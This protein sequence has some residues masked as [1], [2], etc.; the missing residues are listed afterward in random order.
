MAPRRAPVSR[1]ETEFLGAPALRSRMPWNPDT[2]RQFAAERAAPAQDLLGLISVR[3]RRVIDLGCG[4]GEHTAEL[5]GRFPAAEVTGLDSSAEMLGGAR[6]YTQP[7]LT[8]EQARIEDLAGAY[9]LIFSNAALQWLPKHRELLA[10]LWSHLHPG[11]QL[12]VQVPSN[13]DHPS[14]RLLAETAQEAPFRGALGDWTRGGTAPVS[15]QSPV[16]GIVQYGEALFGLGGQDIV[17]F[18]K[19]YPVVLQDADGV[20]AW[21]SGTALPAYL[22]RLPEAL[23]HDFRSAYRWKLWAEWPSGPIFYAFKRTLFAA[24]RP[25]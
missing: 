14:H 4:T 2:Y 10:R 22:E 25:S 15:R 8:F 5:A 24:T 19:I 11:G 21:T 20:L 12:A 7:N 1:A 18:E 9:D 13:F 17:A 3:P 16:L 6:E 23:R